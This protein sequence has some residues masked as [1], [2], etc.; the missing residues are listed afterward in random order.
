MTGKGYYENSQEIPL[1]NVETWMHEEFAVGQKV[2]SIRRTISEGEAMT[3]D[4]LVA[5]ARVFSY[6]AYKSQE[7]AVD[8]RA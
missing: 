2:R 6:G 8:R 3:F 7:E 1:Y 5:G 4:C